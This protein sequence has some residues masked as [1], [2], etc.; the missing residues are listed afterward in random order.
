RHPRRQSAM[1]SGRPPGWRERPKDE[2]DRI[3]KECHLLA[4]HVTPLFDDTS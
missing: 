3:L 4:R 1:R 2:I